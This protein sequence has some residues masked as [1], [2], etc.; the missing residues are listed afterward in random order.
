LRFA[1]A[2][3]PDQYPDVLA[4]LGIDPRFD[5]HRFIVAFVEPDHFSLGVSALATSGIRR[6]RETAELDIPRFLANRAAAVV[7]CASKDAALA[8][9]EDDRPH[10]VIS[11]IE[12]PEWRRRGSDSSPA[13]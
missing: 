12:M 4:S 2:V 3:W 10:V 6:V 11:D 13:P 7:T 5:V 1:S 8:L 9:L